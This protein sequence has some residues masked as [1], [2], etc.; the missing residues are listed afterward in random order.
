MSLAISVPAVHTTLFAAGTEIA[1]DI[2][3]IY[4]ES[5]GISSLWFFYSIKKVFAA[6]AHEGLEDPIPPEIRRRYN[7]PSLSSALVYIHTPRRHADAAAA[8]KRFAF[9]EVFALQ[10]VM[11]QR[12]RTLLSEK[13]LDR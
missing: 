4:P 10:I 2:Y 9:E 8:R 3:P 13:A 1:S 5:Q 6:R 12:R 11:Q 7:L